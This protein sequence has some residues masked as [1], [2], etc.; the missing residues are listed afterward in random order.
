[1]KSEELKWEVVPG[2]QQQQ[3]L[4]ERVE[5]DD[6][7]IHDR[8]DPSIEDFACVLLATEEGGSPGE[9]ANGTSSLIFFLGIGVW[10]N[11][12]EEIDTRCFMR[13]FYVVLT[14]ARSF[15]QI[16]LQST[17]PPRSRYDEENTFGSCGKAS[18]ATGML[19]RTKASSTK[20][21]LTVCFGLGIDSFVL[22]GGEL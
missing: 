11:A 6:Q 22:K 7:G 13:L 21:K 12:L 8:N 2:Q 19:H 10:S 15:A 17:C 4:L 14:T 9:K 18:K 3:Q 1:M 20:V 16:T 5:Y